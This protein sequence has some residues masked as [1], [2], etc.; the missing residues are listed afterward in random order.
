MRT[1]V[2]HDILH[3]LSYSGAHRRYRKWRTER[4]VGGYFQV[5]RH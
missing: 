2:T 1:M 5:S 3:Y 4:E